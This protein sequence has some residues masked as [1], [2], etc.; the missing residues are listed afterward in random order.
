MTTRPTIG[1][2]VLIGPT[3]AGKT[4]V[5]QALS[6]LIEWPLIELDSLREDWYPEF[7]LTPDAEAE[8]YQRGGLPEL[9]YTW[10]PYELLSVERV[11]QEYPERTIIAFGGGQAVYVEKEHIARA[12]AALARAGRVILLQPA[13][14]REHNLAILGERIQQVEFVQ[15]QNTPQDFIR[16]FTPILQMQLESESMPYLATELIVTGQSSPE[17]LA[18]HI[19]ATG[20]TH[21]DPDEN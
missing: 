9:I 13:E 11:M 3:G 16:E 18:R 15:G 5:G 12:K 17:E 6:D 1:S 14:S 8:A 2:I 20:T 19:V 4:A 10:K 21:S 7:G